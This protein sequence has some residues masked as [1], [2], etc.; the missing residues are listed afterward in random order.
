MSLHDPATPKQLKYAQDLARKARVYDNY[1]WDIHPWTKCEMTELIDKL[2]SDL[3]MVIK[4]RDTRPLPGNPTHSFPSTESIGETKFVG[5]FVVTYSGSSEKEAT[6][7]L[8]NLL[9]TN[10]YG[11]GNYEVT[12]L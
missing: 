11:L 12:K 7:K 10:G 1:A 3:G 8:L 4:Q 5:V 2:R 6:E 9:R